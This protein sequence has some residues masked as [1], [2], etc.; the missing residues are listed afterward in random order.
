MTRLQMSEATRIVRCIHLDLKY[1]AY[2]NAMKTFDFL[3][4]NLLYQSMLLN[5]SHSFESFTR[6][7]KVVELSTTT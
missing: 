4:E 3:L 6:Y 2:L 5:H 1:H 7:L